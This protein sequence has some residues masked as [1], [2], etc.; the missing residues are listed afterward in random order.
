MICSRLG[1]IFLNQLAKYDG[2]VLFDT[3]G[4]WTNALDGGNMMRY[5]YIGCSISV[6]MLIAS[7][8]YA[9]QSAGQLLQSGL[10]KEEVEGDLPGAI[11]IYEQILRDFPDE[12]TIAAKALLRMGLSYE[13]LGTA[14]AQKAYRRLLQE[15]SDQMEIAQIARERL[16]QL[17][18]GLPGKQISSPTYRMVMSDEALDLHPLRV[19]KFDFSTD[20]RIVLSGTGEDQDKL[21]ISDDTGTIIRP[22]N[23]ALVQKHRIIHG[24]WSTD[25]QLI[26]YVTGRDSGAIFVVKPDGSSLRQIGPAI[27]GSRAVDL[28]WAHDSKHLVYSALDG[29]KRNVYVRSM[30]DGT[31]R[32]ILEN[33]GSGLKLGE[34][35]PDGRWLALYM[36][37]RNSEG[38]MER[39]VW[40]IPYT[41]GSPINLTESP[42]FDAYPTWARDG[43]S[44]Y[45]VSDRTGDWNIWRLGLD[46]ETGS[47]VGEARKIT[48]FSDSKVVFPKVIS[49][50]GRI[51]F[52]L[53]RTAATIVVADS[54]SPGETYEVTRGM[55]PQPSPDGQTIYYTSQAP[56]M[57]GIYSIPK[58]GGK[59]QRLT[60]HLP[61]DRYLDFHLSPD[62]E[63]IVYFA[64]IVDKSNNRGIFVIPATG[65]QPNIL[66]ELE[67]KRSIAPRW[68]PDGSR[69]A[70]IY[71]DSLYV[72][73]PD[74]GQPRKLAQLNKWESWSIHWSPDGKSIAAFGYPNNPPKGQDEN[75]IFVIP[76]SGGEPKQLTP[77]N[78]YKEGLEWHP[79]GK[80]LTYHVSQ[81]KSE[82]RQVYLDGGSPS[83]LVDHDNPVFWDYVGA[84]APDGD[85]FFF[86]SY[87]VE[88]KGRSGVYIYHESTGKITL[89]AKDAS[90]PHW[91]LD[92]KTIV[93]ITGK[94]VRQLWV[95]EGFLQE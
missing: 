81:D 95:V 77:A 92:G 51:A 9:Q 48:S 32:L 11:Q 22:L 17:D 74:G 18:A 19:A 89:F 12:R 57:P 93:W 86:E 44:I 23:N 2:L 40:L 80:R 90:M 41:G 87:D 25:G 31:D 43:R 46:P 10:Y 33:I 75:A 66:L 37:D 69:I 28:I 70:Y 36:K 34:C 6:L 84:W 8:G 35:S 53:S 67:T 61:N 49:E 15:F 65:G 21:Y 62:G 54:S 83:L 59:S 60:R 64:D 47:S 94:A 4:Y 82:T 56:D 1:H 13:K 72:I 42:G 30:G 73:N 50:G 88:D 58:H 55:N 14:E 78:I 24:R 38:G 91:S 79:N 16:Q 68:S 20:G 63:K 76:E 85:R 45:F 29:V 7:W 3:S 5:Q 27:E 52:G 39:D 26:A 71:G